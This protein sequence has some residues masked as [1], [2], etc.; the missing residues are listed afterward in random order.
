M[1]YLY[2]FGFRP[3]EQALC[4]LE[5]RMF[6]GEHSERNV[7]QS[8]VLI[9]PSRSP[10]IRERLFIL[11]RANSMEQ[12]KEQVADIS[13]GD[14]RYKVFCL[15]RERIAGDEKWSLSNRRQLERTLGLLVEG[16][17][18]LEQ[19]ELL[20]G[21]V[22]LDGEWLFGELVEGEAVWL[23]HQQ[24]PVGYSTALSAKHARALVNIAVPHIEGV[25]LID[26]CC[27]VGTVLIEAC[28]MGVDVTGRDMNWFVTSGSRENLAHFGYECDVVLGPIEEATGHYDVALID[29]PYNVFTH[30]SE[31]AKSSIIESAHVLADRVV[32]VSSE[33]I[34]EPILVAGFKIIDRCEILKQ[35]FKRTVFVCE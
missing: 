25:R 2:T 9:E 33:M 10:F 13:A 17:V 1:S 7:L 5:M 18:D 8:D 29:M 34:E 28:S 31:E 4:Q 19:P 20:Y 27:G 26:P 23:K 6:F 22:Y 30:S 14:K 21:V 12:L 24:R 11:T 16:E 35:Q 3:E 15:H 32:F